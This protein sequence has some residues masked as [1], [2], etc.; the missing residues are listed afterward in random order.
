MSLSFNVGGVD[1]TIRMI[2]GVVLAAIA[3]FGILPGVYAI[4]A[5]I[6]AAVAF[7]TGLVKFCPAYAIVGISSCK[8][9]N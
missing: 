6:I 7:V 2:V 5:Y 8:A 1:R 4:V 9:K 3:Y